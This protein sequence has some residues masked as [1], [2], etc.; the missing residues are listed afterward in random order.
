MK[1]ENFD[2]LRRNRI[3]G[4]LVTAGVSEQ[5][6][7]L[8]S[9]AERCVEAVRQRDTAWDVLN[10]LCMHVGWDRAH[11]LS[12]GINWMA[13]TQGQVFGAVDETERHRPSFGRAEAFRE[14]PFDRELSRYFHSRV[15]AGLLLLEGNPQLALRFLERVNELLPPRTQARLSHDISWDGAHRVRRALRLLYDRFED[16]EHSLQLHRL[17]G[18]WGASEQHFA[19]A[20]TYLTRWVERLNRGAPV[21]EAKALLDAAYSLMVD[22]D[23]AAAMRKQS[24]SACPRDSRE[25]WA[26]L[27]GL[28]VGRIHIENPYLGEAF[29]QECRSSGW[30]AGWPAV[31]VMVE[32]NAEWS[33]HRE[34]CL[35]LYEAASVEY[36]DLRLWGSRQPAHMS[37]E[38]NLYWAMRV[39]YCDAHLES[40]QGVHTPT[41]AEIADQLQRIKDIG[42]SNSIRSMRSFE[43]IKQEVVAVR[44]SV[45]F[46]ETARAIVGRAIGEAAVRALPAAT[47]EHLVGAWLARKQGHLHDARVAAFRAIESVFSRLIMSRLLEHDPQLKIQV[48]ASSHSHRKRRTRKIE[49]M[50]LRDWAL[51]LPALANGSEQDSNLRTALA[52]CFPKV[53]LHRLGQCSPALLDASRARGQSAHDP[54]KEDYDLA[55]TKADRLWSI[56]VGSQGTPGLIS[57]LCS[58]LGVTQGD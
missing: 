24:P 41:P 46:Q 31:S 22:A 40:D 12:S 23:C 33:R 4:A 14:V 56:A 18:G 49:N 1:Y 58:A 32:E 51:V 13:E 28:L 17:E 36:K 6:S 20:E 34:K 5:R 45:P 42:S 35:L 8:L 30:G 26:W 54:N 55:L 2:A 16:Y 39:G 15:A 44:E 27:Y 7:S 11:D 25:F 47:I 53:D 9:A 29:Q 52:L 50:R 21:E 48:H 3:E 19:E 57:E 10:A 37:P 38:S 43:E